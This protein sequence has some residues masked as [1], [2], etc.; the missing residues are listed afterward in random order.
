MRKKKRKGGWNWEK[1]RGMKLAEGGGLEGGGV[2]GG[3][4]VG[5]EGRGLEG[6]GLAERGGEVGGGGVGGGGELE[7]GKSDD[8]GYSGDKTNIK[9]TVIKMPEL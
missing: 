5:G 9:Q 2:R 7:G 1:G 8:C 4:G 6:G 3:G